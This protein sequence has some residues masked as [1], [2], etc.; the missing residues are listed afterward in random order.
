MEYSLPNTDLLR[1]RELVTRGF[2]TWGEKP[3][4]NIHFADGSHYEHEGEINFFDN[5]VDPITSVIKSRASFP[6][7]DGVVLPGQ[8]VRIAIS[9]PVLTKAIAIPRSSI[10]ETSQG[11]MVLVVDK[12]NKVASRKIKILLNMDE[13]AIVEDGLKSGERIVTEGIG[14]LK[15][16]QLIQEM[17]P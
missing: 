17:K 2:A 15:D 10:L 1:L 5:K 16:G 8:F 9:G 12:E 14:K 7:P 3:K 4:A 11:A 6:N 13:N